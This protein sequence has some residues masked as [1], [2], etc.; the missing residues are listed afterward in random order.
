MRFS[1]PMPLHSRLNLQL[2]VLVLVPTA[3]L[4]IQIPIN[5][6][7]KGIKEGRSTAHPCIDVGDLEEAPS[8]KLAQL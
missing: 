8:F 3:P 7:G 1:G 2:Q 6:S 5:V 4:S